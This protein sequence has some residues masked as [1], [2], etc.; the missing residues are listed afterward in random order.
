MVLFECN[1]V[2]FDLFIP[3]EEKKKVIEFKEDDENYDIPALKEPSNDDI[4]EFQEHPI[5]SDEPVLHL[6][7]DSDSEEE[8][9]IDLNKLS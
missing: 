6:V 3:K 8:D 4:E 7:L 1:R 9:E 2:P 5:V